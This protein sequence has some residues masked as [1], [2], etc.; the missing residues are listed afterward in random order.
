MC[1]VREWAGRDSFKC[2][3]KLE[4]KEAKP[5]A[6]RSAERMSGSTRLLFYCMNTAMPLPCPYARADTHADSKNKIPHHRPRPGTTV[7]AQR[8]QRLLADLLAE[9]KN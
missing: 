1:R 5:R 9:T 3:E 7:R 6:R 8:Q 2:P 4:E